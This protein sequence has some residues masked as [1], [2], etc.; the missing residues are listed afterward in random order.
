M[1]QEIQKLTIYTRGTRA[2]TVEDVEA[3]ASY[4]EDAIIF[5]LLDALGQRNGAVAAQK[6]HLLLESERDPKHPLY[7]LAMIARRFRLLIQVKEL[8]DLGATNEKTA[9][10]LK[11]HPFPTRKLRR[12]SAHFTAGQLAAVHRQILDIDVAIKT[13]RID[14]EV[15]LDLLVAGVAAPPV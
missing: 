12:Q 3:V 5:D 15:A 6:L 14:P 7:V 11:L 1:D 4:S 9:K 13:G 8:A 10:A 2:V